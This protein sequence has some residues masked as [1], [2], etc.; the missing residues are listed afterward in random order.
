M[1]KQHIGQQIDYVCHE[2]TRISHQLRYLDGTQLQMLRVRQSRLEAERERLQ[3]MQV[4]GP[5]GTAAFIR[6]IP[7]RKGLSA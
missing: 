6:D 4:S 5:F 1:N 2:L 3:A 7:P